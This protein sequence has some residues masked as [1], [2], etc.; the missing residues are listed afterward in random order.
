MKKAILIC[1]LS[2]L[3]C[4]C[5]NPTISKGNALNTQTFNTPITITSNE[6][7]LQTAIN[8]S[9]TGIGTDSSPIIISNLANLFPFFLVLQNTS[10]Y[11]EITNNQLTIANTQITSSILF[12]NVSNGLI[13]NNKFSGHSN[14]WNGAEPYYQGSFIAFNN[15]S[16]FKINNNY[17]GFDGFNSIAL[18][19]SRN[20]IISNNEIK[21][22]YA[23]IQS[24]P[25]QPNKNITFDNNVVTTSNGIEL[26]SKGGKI[27]NNIF[28]NA[29][30]SY[31]IS[32]YLN[33]YM[34]YSN[35]SLNGRP[36]QVLI[37]QSNILL[38]QDYGEII[39]VK[40][41]NITIENQTFSNTILGINAYLS[42]NISISKSTFTNLIFSIFFVRTN[43]IVINQNKFTNASLYVSGGENISLS[44]NNAETSEF[45]FSNVKNVQIL[46][47][48]IEKGPFS[49]IYLGDA[50]SS[51]I[52][53]NR[54]DNCIYTGLTLENTNFTL[55]KSNKIYNNYEFGIDVST[56]YNNIFVLNQIY[57]NKKDG[58][59]WGTYLGQK[60]NTEQNNFIYNNNGKINNGI[61]IIILSG[62]IFLVALCIYLGY[63]KR[64]TIQLFVQHY[65]TK[66]KELRNP[67]FTSK[68]ICIKC[69]SNIED[70][71]SI[72]CSTCGEIIHH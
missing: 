66:R 11:F 46:N 58:I 52:E 15:C 71:E 55:I 67:F 18:I 70:G 16:N 42:T 54:I 53:N 24:N 14:E 8:M 2:L 41:S 28:K 63:R 23:G 22:Q 39:L 61:N 20:I 13:L 35:N 3:L 26:Y 72:F 32:Y 57:N 17:F 5:L 40:S 62:T 60:D 49:C 37:N 45:D 25:F 43:Y 31:T 51:I 68:M 47:N 44:D 50:N 21:Y 64:H 65:V 48:I 6:N 19:N 12:L 38:S 34:K 33:D 59:Y 30:L 27:Y 56:S 29:G 36:I 1:F 69:G 4:N 7:F 9:W 10:L